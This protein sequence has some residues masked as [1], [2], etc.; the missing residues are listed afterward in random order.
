MFG[1][2]KPESCAKDYKHMEVRPVCKQYVSCLYPK[3]RQA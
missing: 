3:T 1:K 2:S